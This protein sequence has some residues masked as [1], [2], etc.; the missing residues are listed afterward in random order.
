M[1]MSI[2]YKLMLGNEFWKIT[3]THGAVI[4]AISPENDE[5]LAGK[6]N[7]CHIWNYLCLSG[8]LTL[9]ARDKLFEGQAGVI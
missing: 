7:I 3:K 9:L 1:S 4:T 6:S 5:T 2:I 8:K